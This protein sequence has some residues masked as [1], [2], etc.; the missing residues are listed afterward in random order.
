MKTP[1]SRRRRSR[2]PTQPG[3]ATVYTN[4]PKRRREAIF[5]NLCTLLCPH[6][7]LARPR[8]ATVYTNAPKRRREAIFANLCTLLCPHRPLAR[9]RDA[10]VYTNAPER[11]R[12]A[13]FANLCTLLRPHGRSRDP[14]DATVY[15]N[16][17]ERRREPIFANL[18]TLLRPPRPLARPP[19]R[20]SVHKCPKT[21][22]RGH[23]R[24]SVYTP[25]PPP[26]ARATGRGYRFHGVDGPMAP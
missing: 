9:P 7:P 4:A 24:Q 6:R 15:T 2:H 16:A 5:A 10:T 21:A 1:T 23:F 26:S 22:S 3:V 17:P 14:R 18:C 8:G 12:E 19:R 11:L 25:A 20:N 13:I